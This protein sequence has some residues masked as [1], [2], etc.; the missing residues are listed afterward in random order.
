M[1]SS[2]SQGTTSCTSQ[3]AG[4][5]KHQLAKAADALLM[6][7]IFSLGAVYLGFKPKCKSLIRD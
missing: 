7:A 3:R 5:H 2:G 4:A 1:I 6:T